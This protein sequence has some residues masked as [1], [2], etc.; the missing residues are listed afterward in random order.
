MYIYIYKI[1]LLSCLVFQVI[2]LLISQSCSSTQ[3]TGERQYSTLP[4]RNEGIHVISRN[5][6]LFLSTCRLPVRASSGSRTAPPPSSSS[7]IRPLSWVPSK[8]PETLTLRR[9]LRMNLRSI[10]SHSDPQVTFFLR[11]NFSSSRWIPGTRDSIALQCHRRWRSR[12]PLVVLR[13]RASLDD[14]FRD[15][16]SVFPSPT[17]L[18]LLFLPAIGLAAGASLYFSNSWNRTF[19]VDSV[20]GDWVLFTSPTPFNRSVLLRCPSVSFEDGGVLL[21]GVNDRLLREERHYVNLSRGRIPVS[22]KEGEKRP[23]EEIQYQRLCL[24]TDDGGVI[25]LDWPENLELRKE[26]GLDTTVLIVPGTPEGSM[27]RCIKAF[28][29]DALQ[30]GYFPIVMN[31]RGCAGS[32]LTTPR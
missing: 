1:N 12:R 9:F 20:V 5:F 16:I 31:P 17:S 13:V 29:F 32:P 28:V 4:P 18:D 10:H 19:D 24:R 6:R 15:V 27:G 23:E 7:T 25:S 26:H 21:E 3:F 22:I 8:S 30:H 2:T 14:L 11:R